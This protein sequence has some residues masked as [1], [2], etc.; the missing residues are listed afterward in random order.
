MVRLLELS[1]LHLNMLHMLNM[2]LVCL[3]RVVM[4]EKMCRGV[5]KT[6]RANGI[7]RV[8]NIHILICG[9]RLLKVEKKY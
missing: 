3:P 8:A 9:Q 1:L 5:I 7:Q 6:I 2:E 4:V